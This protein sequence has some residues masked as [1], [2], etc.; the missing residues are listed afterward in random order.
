MTDASSTFIEPPKLKGGWPLLGQIV[1]FAR[2]PYEFMK[3]ASDTTGEIVQ[4]KM[5]NQRIIL[6]MGDEASG[7]FYKSSDEQLDQSA[8]YQLMVPIFGEG[9]LF[10][11][12]NDVKNQ[13]LR[14][15]LPSLRME[16]MRMHA[17]TINIEV[18]DMMAKWGDEGEIDLVEEMKQLTINTAS[19]CLLGT[20]FRY[21]L[22]EE[23][24]QIY[25]DLEKGVNALAY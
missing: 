12:T 7:I 11:A 6:L 13:Q 21:E 24:T 23:F 19:H 17:N 4:F 20:E 16:A 25:H 5:F 2:N 3:R 10:D 22:T 1:N 9:I 18:K 8:A 14:M 15:L